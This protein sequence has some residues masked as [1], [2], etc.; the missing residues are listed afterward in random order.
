M[1]TSEES[2][3]PSSQPTGLETAILTLGSS[4]ATL[5]NS[6]KA[7]NDRAD[8]RAR[9]MLYLQGVASA[10]LLVGTWGII[11]TAREVA[12][13]AAHIDELVVTVATMAAETRE[14]REAADETATLAREAADSA[15]R[16]EV[17]PPERKGG[18][19]TAALVI[20]ARPSRPA[21]SATPLAS[22]STAEP[23]VEEVSIPLALPSAGPATAGAGP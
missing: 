15:P 16:I 19:P 4:I 8:R 17:T 20:P 13:T 22:A 3:Y 6:A 10:L 2:S 14:N 7:D 11:T 5:A 18:K 23:R 21:T 1:N 9:V 12:S